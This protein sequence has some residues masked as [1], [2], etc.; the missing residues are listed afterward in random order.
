MST[1]PLNVAQLFTP[2]PSGV[3][4]NGNVPLLPSVETWLGAML[5]VAAQVQLPTT[6]WQSGSPERTIMALEAVM[7]SLSDANISIMAQG[8]FLQSAS[9]G[10]VTYTTVQGT[11]VTVPVTPDPSNAAQNPGASAG[12][13]DALSQ[14]VYDTFR[15]AATYA[16]GPLAIVKTSAG[17]LGPYAVGTYH[18]GSVAGPTYNNPAALTIPS[19]LIAGTGGV[20]TGVS[21]SVS[22]TII[23]TQSAHGLTAGQSVYVVIPLA[24]DISGLNGVFA[25]VTA[26]TATTF[27]ISFGSSGSYTGTG[28]T[29]YLCTVQTMQA[30]VA[31]I[32]SNAGPSQVTTTI[33]Q[34][35]NVFC[36]NLV[37]WS[38]SNWETNQRLVSRCLL[39]LASRSP[40]GPSQAYVYFAESAQQLLAEATPA[41]ALTNGPVSATSFSTPGTGI[42]QTVVASATPANTTLG[43]NVTPGCSGLLV[44]G[45]TLA[46]PCVIT[47]AGPTSLAPGQSM[48]VTIDGILGP[49]I[50]NGTFLATYVGADV[51]SIPISTI[52]Q[53]TY[54]GGGSVDGG[55]LGQIDA[56]LQE[57]V[58]PDNTTA[59]TVSALALPIQVVATVVV[60][61]AYVAAYQL[62]AIAQLQTQIASYA[63]GGN[64]PDFAVA[65]DDIVGA[66][67][68]AGVV[69][70][71]QASYVRQ[72]QS[73][74]LNGGAVNVGVPFPLLT[75]Q[76][77]LSNPL[78]TVVGV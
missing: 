57:N 62:A 53:P 74:S 60:P 46:N 63:V 78:V 51:F 2:M 18:V 16:S 66:L 48:T 28:G 70:L 52:G 73:L 65:Y 33:T 24:S 50:A 39:S 14:G 64:A 19:S 13:L 25:L 1:P 72:I 77:V 11:V 10:T 34:N 56:L 75:Y 76:A 6:A 21:S 37:G 38:G 58:V 41:Y 15:L 67:E 17:T 45:V 27:Q 9:T 69:Q 22:S 26:A 12:W 32:G 3:G 55:D 59:I 7:F 40:N 31:G 44:T 68:E 29:V 5:T 20:I 4:P 36:S 35:A 49:T 42:Q 8:G 71:G 23:T 43:S 47:C 61:Q 54:L 30:D